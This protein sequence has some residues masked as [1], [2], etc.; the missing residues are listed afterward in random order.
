MH[1]GG[2]QRIL[3]LKMQNY[4]MTDV[5]IYT[6]PA[7]HYCHMAKEYF[8]ENDIAYEEYDVAKDTVAREEMVERS[9]QFGVPVIIIDGNLIIG[10]DRQRINQLLGL[11]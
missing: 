4:F 3:A 8:A 2:T 10:F 1:L 9:G 5:K 6:I 11:E 7:C